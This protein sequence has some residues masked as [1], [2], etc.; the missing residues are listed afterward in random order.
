[1]NLSGWASLV[2]AVGL[3]L[4]AVGFA[5]WRTRRKREL[6]NRLLG[7]LRSRLSGAGATDVETLDPGGPRTIDRF[8][9]KG[10]TYRL[11]TDINPVFSGSFNLRLSTYVDSVLEFEL[12]PAD[13]VGRPLPPPLNSDPELRRCRLVTVGREESAA[14]LATVREPL[15]RVFPGRWKAF[16]KRFAELVLSANRFDPAE[17]NE[18][19][20]TADL[21]V[22]EAAARVPAW[23]NPSGGTWTYREGW[24]RHVAVWHWKPAQRA[25]LAEGTRR[26]GVSAWCDNAY[27]NRPIAGMLKRLAGNAELLWITS[28][29]DLRFLEE[30]F[31]Q[32][33]KL[34]GAIARLPQLNM[35]V[36]ADQQLDGDF[37][38]G[39]LA[40]EAGVV[41]E[42]IARI[43]DAI[44]HGFHDAA[45]DVLPKARF[46]A[47]RLYD[48]E[49]SWFSGEYEIVSA[50]LSDAD[51]RSAL[52]AEAEPANARVL[53]I[54]RPFSFKLLR[55]DRLETTM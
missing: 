32:A 27:L 50:A 24:E 40:V 43:H 29:R 44:K 5:I 7:E 46:Y 8:R 22:I 3:P 20:M 21:E 1:M 34:D 55:D 42:A 33:A 4:A 52:E 48:D 11:G 6:R 15:I 54:E 45:L 49:F 37:F 28:E 12:A 26:W 36:V 25:R 10:R 47:R 14:Y 19:K 13:H 41:D 53:T 39:V 30:A 51:V 2:F 18:A 35:A 9:W 31:G 17:W 23:R 16:S 38:S